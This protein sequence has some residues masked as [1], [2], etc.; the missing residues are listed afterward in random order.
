MKFRSTQ[1]LGIALALILSGN[2]ASAGGKLDDAT[3]LAIFDQANMTD[4]STGRLGLKKGHS[5]EVKTLARMVVNDHGHA[6][7][8]GREVAHT[9]GIVPLPPDNDKSVENQA[10]ALAMLEAKSGTEFDRAYLLHE[11]A[12]HQ[13]VIEAIQTTLLPAAKSAQLKELITQVLPGFQHHLAE[14]GVSITGPSSRSRVR[15]P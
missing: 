14:T 15:G 11:I 10:K 1:M 4:I 3:I 5:E 12:F 7:H 13:S 2:P 9:L 8:M 6:Q